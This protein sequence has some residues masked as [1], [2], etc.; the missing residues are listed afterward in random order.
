[1][2]WTEGRSPASPRLGATEDLVGVEAAVGSMGNDRLTRLESEP[3][4]VQPDRDL[5]GLEGNEVR[6]PGDLR[7]GPQVGPGRLPVPADVVVAAEPL[8]GT[9]GLALGRNERTLVDVLA[10]H[11]PARS[12]SGLEQHDGPD[13]IRDR[14]GA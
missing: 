10:T 4:V 6:D 3:P 13:G 14:P 8:V 5:V 11:V 1:M 9:E 7:P 12:K 2:V